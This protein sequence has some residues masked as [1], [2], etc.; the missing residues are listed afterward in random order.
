M[1]VKLFGFEIKRLDGQTEQAVNEKEKTFVPPQY[2]DG[3]VTISNSGSYFGTYVD[4]DGTVRNEIELITKY[5]ELSIQPELEEAIN[6]ICNEAIVTDESGKC[7]SINVDN[8]KQSD[9]FKKKV[10]EEF[11]EVLKLLDFNNYA[12]DIF[13]NWYIDGRLFYHVVIDETA[14]Y[15]GIKEIRYIDP[16]KIRKVRE[17]QREKDPRTGVDVIKQINEYYVYYER[18]ITQGS[19]SNTMGQKIAVDSIV[20]VNSGLLDA[21]RTMVLSY[22]HKAIKPFNQLR[23]LEDATVIYRLARAPERRLF[24]ID[25]GS[26]PTVKAEQYLK[27][28][29]AQYRTKLVY[30]ANTGEIR[31]D[32]RHMAMLEDIWLPRREGG[33]G[34]EIGTLPGGQNLGVIEDVEYF[35]NKLYKALGVPLSRLQPQT[36]FSLGRSTEITREELN[37]VKFINRLRNKFSTLFDELLKRQLVLKKICNE[38]DWEILSEDIYYTFLRDNNFDE[39]KEAELLANKIEVLGRIDPY[40]GRYFSKEWVRKKVLLQTDEDIEAIDKQIEKERKIEYEN[41]PK[42]DMGI[43]LPMGGNLGGDGPGLEPQ[44][45]QAPQQQDRG[46][47]TQET[48]EIKKTS[49]YSI[50]DGDMLEV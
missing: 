13:R 45:P 2:D 6:Q 36:G 32:R 11:D 1:A 23:M 38:R 4:L 42:D 35:N 26:L 7:V 24:Y 10:I 22:L 33:K 5:R 31:D 29:M 15:L 44:N 27:S 46:G 12:Y 47:E 18:G 39:L 21:R 3:A 48:T 25:V 17:I 20:N 16:R 37:F 19:H 40:V 41:R 14:P 50:G 9:K 49:K 34:T 30:D 8:V 43:P 28:I